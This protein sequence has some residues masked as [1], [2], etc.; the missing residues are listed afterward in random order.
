MKQEKNLKK[1]KV[2]K[3]WETGEKHYEDCGQ[4]NIDFY[5]PCNC[6]KRSIAFKGW[7]IEDLRICRME[8]LGQIFDKRL[9]YKTRDRFDNEVDYHCTKT[10]AETWKREH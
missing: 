6:Y 4:V 8:A 1:V 9:M 2:I 10:C 3:H 7:K 5:G